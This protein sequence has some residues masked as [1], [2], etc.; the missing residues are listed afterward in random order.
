LVNKDLSTIELYGGAG[1]FSLMMAK[2]LD[3]L[4]VNEI[5]KRAISNGQFN[6]KQNNL[7]NID[8]IASDASFFIKKYNDVLQIFVD[9]PRAGMDSKVIENINNSKI[10]RII[11]VS[12]NPAT[13]SRDLADLSKS[14]FK[15]KK[16]KI[17]DNFPSTYHIELISEIER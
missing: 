1:F 4:M 6:A 2:K 10:Q 3:K 14:G 15:L 5:S 11:Y 17:I 9:P 7:D 8:F 16:L 12:C 13:F